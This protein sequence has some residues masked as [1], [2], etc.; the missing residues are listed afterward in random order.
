MNKGSKWHLLN[1]SFFLLGS[2]YFPAV[3]NALSLHPDHASL[4]NLGREGMSV[5]RGTLSSLPSFVLNIPTISS[6]PQDIGLS[7]LK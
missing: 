3:H 6:V 7:I 2:F 1:I 5:P 4:T